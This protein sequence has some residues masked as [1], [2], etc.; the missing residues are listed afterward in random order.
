MI[1][2]PRHL[3]Q[4]TT[5]IS[6]AAPSLLRTL[7]L[8]HDGI[9]IGATIRALEKHGLLTHLI[10]HGRVK[11]RELVDRYSCNPGYLHVA[12]RC[13][14]AQGW[15]TRAGVPG[16]DTMVFEVTPLGEIAAKTFP[17][18]AEVA[19][20][21]YSGIPMERYLFHQRDLDAASAEHYAR[22]SRR[23]IQDWDLAVVDPA[24]QESRL[25]EI[26]RK[27]LDGILV[28]PF[29]IAAKLRGL[30]EGEEFACDG[31][32]GPHDNLR[33]GLA[34]I[35]HLGWVLPEGRRYLFTELGRVACQFTLH[36]GLTLSYWPMFC[37]LP[38]LFFDSSHHVTHVAPGHEETHVDRSL[39]VLA[40]GVAHRPYFE[41]S[42]QILIA[43]FNR[44]PLAEQPR[45]VAD[46]GCGDGIWLK[47]IYEIV[48]ATTLRGRHLGEYPLLMIG[49]DYNAKALEAARRT[50]ETS[51]VPN[52]TLFG[53]V[54]DPTL[55][56]Q[57]LGE[58]GIDSVDGLHIRA[59]I[60]HNRRYTEPRDKAS[61]DKHLVLST[62]AYAGE[63]GNAIPNQLLEQNLVEHLRRWA[64]FIRK[65]GLIVIEAHNIYPPIAAAYNGKT[66]A[67]AFDTY[68]G[69]SNQYPIDYEAFMS[70]AEEAGLR[71]VSHEQRVYPSRLPFVAISLNRF[72]SAEPAA[73]VGR[74]A[75]PPRGPA[76]WRPDGSEDTLDGEALHRFLYHDH[77]LT[78][79]RRWCASSTGMLVHGLLED[80]ERRLD[81]CLNPSRTSRQLTL[82][83]YGAGTGLA[84]L[85]LIKGLRETGL[86]QR[87]QRNGINFKLLLFDFPSGWFAKAFDL[88]NAFTFIDFHSLTDPDSG[89][90]RLISDIIAPESV[91]IIYA[92]MVLHL[93]PPKAMPPLI[94]S[95]AEVLQ[96]RGS[97]YWN[98][99]DTAPASAH[100][101]VIHAPNRALRR[102][103]LDVIDTEARVHQVLANVPADQRSAFADLPQRLAEIRRSLTPERRA[104]AKARA[105]KQILAIPTHVEYIEG[106]LNKCFDGGFATMVSVLSEGDVLALALLPANQRYFNEIE[107]SELRRK[108]ISL[109]LRYD[110][111]PRFRAGPAGNAVGINLH[112]T[113]G[114]HVKNS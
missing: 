15:I 45:F 4:Q 92:S 76:S 42:E 29:M 110:V 74:R 25:N 12:L 109:L 57:A 50:L 59:F 30:L 27:H 98:S 14:A 60:D 58:R 84:T 35:E 20:F 70:L 88:L 41:D 94:D 100:A 69:Y 24:D 85:E 68:H 19:E 106:L 3:R 32:P 21:A 23:C 113:Y 44:E 55:F 8:H 7:F 9:V 102:V 82:V 62:G 114:E 78:R 71:A 61:A 87:M 54:T 103:L 13:L 18:Y 96:P 97:F 63:T 6:T 108:L 80:I 83:D 91:D 47:R 1:A 46:M 39:N 10:S 101:E 73:V 51:G 89:K 16:S 31:L 2:V 107:D 105:D 5:K 86:I 112:W 79:P 64:P 28:S 75:A 99:P 17:L 72:K 53:D 93:V 66:H 77:D 26:I 104:L 56:A 36:Y 38:S 34:A 95:F 90:I 52:I 81:R 40:S 33:A 22:L 111:L 65:H 11:F 48:A 67:T 43:I 49:A 37:R